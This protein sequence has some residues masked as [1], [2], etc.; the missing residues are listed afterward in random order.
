MSGKLVAPLEHQVLRDIRDDFPFRGVGL[1]FFHLSKEKTFIRPG[2]LASP[3]SVPQV[4]E[5]G[6]QK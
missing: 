4:K 3:L 2:P 1:A 5:K 6:S